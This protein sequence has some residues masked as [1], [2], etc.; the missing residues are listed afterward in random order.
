V[1]TSGVRLSHV[2]DVQPSGVKL[3][4]SV[5]GVR[6]GNGCTILESERLFRLVQFRYDKDQY[7]HTRL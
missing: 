1:V 7:C 5:I 6:P 4:L 3:P 2:W